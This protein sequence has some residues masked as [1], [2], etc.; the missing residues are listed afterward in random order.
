MSLPRTCSWELKV[1]C[2]ILELWATFCVRHIQ[3]QLRVYSS[4]ERKERWKETNIP[5]PHSSVTSL[6]SDSP[7]SLSCISLS[8]GMLCLYINPFFLLVQLGVWF[9]IIRNPRSYVWINRVTDHLSCFTRALLTCAL[10]Q[11]FLSPAFAQ[12]HIL[13]FSIQSVVSKTSLFPFPTQV[14]A[15]FGFSFLSVLEWNLLK[16]TTEAEVSLYM[17]EAYEQ[18]M[19]FI[20]PISEVLWYKDRKQKA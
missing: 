7:C 1:R 4:G 14:P 12:Q 11:S 10:G 13:F 20:S 2:V 5:E 3:R 19:E 9:S 17:P 16:E 15:F 6:S 8:W 18:I